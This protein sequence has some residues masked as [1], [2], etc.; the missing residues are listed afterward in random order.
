MRFYKVGGCVRDELLGVK[1]KDIDYSVV[2]DEGDLFD[3]ES[4][5]DFMVEW[6]E[7]LDFKIIRDHR[8]GKIIGSDF[9]TARAHMPGEGVVD[10]VLAR[11]EGNYT[12]GRRP[13]SVEPGS[14]EDD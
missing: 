8:T 9:Y 7:N 3:V 14:L 4:P 13:D 5:F 2:F 6:L 12:D 10:F 1:P 11:R